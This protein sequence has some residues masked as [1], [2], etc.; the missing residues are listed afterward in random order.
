M[1]NKIASQKANAG[2]KATS[3]MERAFT[4][5]YI[6]NPDVKETTRKVMRDRLSSYLT[7]LTET[8]DTVKRL[9]Q[10]GINEF[11]DYLVYQRESG[12]RRISNAQINNLCNV[13]A[14]LVK[15]IATHTEFSH[16]NINKVEYQPLK[17]IKP[18]NEWKKRRPLTEQEI[19]ALLTCRTLT[20]QE[21]EYRDL[22]I[23]ECECGCRISD[24]PKLFNQTAQKH[25]N[26][27]GKEVISIDTQ[28]EHIRAYI[29]V[30][31]IMK[32]YITRYADNGFM[33]AHP[34]NTRTFT[35]KY[36][37]IIRNVARKAGLTGV[38]TF[39]DAN[40]NIKTVRLCDIISS[41]FA[42][43]TFIRKMLQQGYSADELRRLTGHADTTMINE[44]YNVHN[45]DDEANAVF[46]AH[47]RVSGTTA[48]NTCEQQQSTALTTYLLHCRDILSWLGEPRENYADIRDPRGLARL[49]ATRYEVPLAN[50]GWDV[51]AIERLYKDDDTEGY[52]RLKADI[53]RLRLNL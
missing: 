26:T 37:R 12:S 48:D 27:N 6:E 15:V 20:P 24:M 10:R 30:T 8:G 25:F 35:N 17:E 19:T 11:R 51:E 41:H 22:F 1:T 31:D 14:R 28:K 42:R 32:G 46:R 4:I 2:A 43:Y 33:Y 23:M 45:D 53:K 21:Q 38:E 18:K 44:V 9:T 16:Y 49:I 29:L 40:G 13:V 3:L 50:M 52:K 36:N 34:D 47:D 7:F 39:K 5:Y